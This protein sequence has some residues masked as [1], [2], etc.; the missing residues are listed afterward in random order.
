LQL[1]GR[2][3]VEESVS[4]HLP[5][6]Y[7]NTFNSEEGITELVGFM[8]WHGVKPDEL[9][10]AFER[11]WKER[12]QRMLDLEVAAKA[13]HDRGDRA[14]KVN[15]GMIIAHF[16]YLAEGCQLKGKDEPKPPSYFG[17]KRVSEV[18]R[19]SPFR[20][21]DLHQALANHHVRIDAV[22]GRGCGTE[23]VEITLFSGSSNEDLEV[24]IRRGTI[25]QHKDWQHRQNLM[26]ALDYVVIVP[27]GGVASKKLMAY[28]MNKTCA[29]SIGNPMELTEFLFDNNDAMAS[30]GKVWDFFESIFNK[31][32]ALS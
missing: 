23:S 32:L 20:G 17:L 11:Q 1:L 7:Q 26:V 30:Q 10:Q 21:E 9:R 18:S 16:T 13:K 12:K 8:L 22:C 28:C 14:E 5:S 19:G 29:C 31:N 27:A 4:L 3:G 15:S 2:R 25:F 6:L 24:A